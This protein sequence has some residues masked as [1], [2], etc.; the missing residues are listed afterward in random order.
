MEKK[1]MEKGGEEHVRHL[2][3]CSGC[4]WR[5]RN[6]AVHSRI[7]RPLPRTHNAILRLTYRRATACPGHRRTSGHRLAHSRADHPCQ[8]PGRWPPR[9]RSSA[10]DAARSWTNIDSPLGLK[11][12]PGQNH[13]DRCSS[14][15]T[16]RQEIQTVSKDSRERN[17]T[18]LNDKMKF[19]Y[20]SMLFP[21]VCSEQ[22]D[23]SRENVFRN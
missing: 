21:E 11:Y 12:W 9:D 20:K 15:A 17:R 19:T 10:A 16:P 18:A 22:G 13:P 5:W 2:L 14:C 6:R 3:P 23:R 8:V 1:Q 4:S 7:A